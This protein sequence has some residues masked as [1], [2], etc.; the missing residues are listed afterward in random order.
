MTQEDAIA[1]LEEIFEVEP[2]VLKPE[3]ALDS[4]A[5]DSMAMLSVIAFAN[6]HFGKRMTGA[7][8]KTFKTIGDILAATEV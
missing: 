4:L 8:I 2:G 1:G 5:W 6:E 7:Q 3:T